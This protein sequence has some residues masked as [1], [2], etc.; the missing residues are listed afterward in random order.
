MK[1]LQYYLHGL[2]DLFLREKRVLVRVDYNVPI[3][4][5]IIQD[6]ER[7]ERSLPTIR[8]LLNRGNS[9]ILMSHLGRPQ[10]DLD[11]DGHIKA[12]KYTL[13]QLVQPLQS[14]L[15]REVLFAE[16]CG[17]PDSRRKAM[18]L[19]PGQVLLLENTRFHPGETKGDEAF[20]QSL[21]TLGQCY[22][23]DAFGAIHRNHASNA[24]VAHFFPVECKAMGMLIE[25]ELQHIS[26]IMHRPSE[27][28]TL[29]LGGAKVSDKI[30]IIE[31]LLPKVHNILIGGGMAFTFL[32]AMG[33]EI[34]KSILQKSYIE[35]CAR[36]IEKAQ[37]HK[38]RLLLPEDFVVVDPDDP[39]DV[40]SVADVV[41][42]PP[43]KAGYDIGPK[44]L[45]AFEPFILRSKT[46]L[47]NGPMGVFEKE[48]FSRGTNKVASDI[49]FATRN[50]AFSLVGGGDTAAAVKKAGLAHK[51]SYISTGGGALLT[52]FEG[53]PL[54]ALEALA[55]QIADDT[56]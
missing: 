19:K 10:K 16:D 21:A 42:F 6:T 14:L 9:V 48:A 36:I 43:N 18:D 20:A 52:I 23:N 27:P 33:Y 31:R 15:N 11:E 44:T 30:P 3:E 22:V 5:G 17:G 46:I 39:N 37:K 26:R 49:A 47:W 35:V 41:A 40:P 12:E 56:N 1:F 38:V 50:K 24:V 54:P 2:N 7:I 8:E 28:F 32:K 53:K 51:M 13:R 34:G 45:Y 4:N 55:Y 29:I 25:E